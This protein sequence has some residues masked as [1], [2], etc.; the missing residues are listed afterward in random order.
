[1]V[2][3]PPR[4]IYEQ[5]ARTPFSRDIEDWRVARPL[6]YTYTGY[7]KQLRQQ[8]TTKSP[9]RYTP[10]GERST[11]SEAQYTVYK[12]E[13]RIGRQKRWEARKLVLNAIAEDIKE[14]DSKSKTLC[15]GWRNRSILAEVAG[16][17]DGQPAI[18]K[19]DKGLP[20]MTEIDK[21]EKAPG[22]DQSSSSDEEDSAG[23]SRAHGRSSKTDSHRLR[24]PAAKG[25]NKTTRTS[26]AAPRGGGRKRAHLSGSEESDEGNVVLSKGKAKKKLNTKNKRQKKASPKVWVVPDSSEESEDEMDYVRRQGLEVVHD[27]WPSSERKQAAL[28][29]N[30]KKINKTVS[31][32][33]GRLSHT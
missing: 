30:A 23:K 27:F 7:N 11:W 29:V 33:M 13:R 4:K 24:V 26:S 32:E 16:R 20:A 2:P 19:D 17:K 3:P 8:A 31:P 9:K 5:R 18:E 10:R 15:D 14:N 12:E 28:Q 25:A 21:G 6:K 22:D 1:M